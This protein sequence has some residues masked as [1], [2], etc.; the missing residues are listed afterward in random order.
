MQTTKPFPALPMSRR[1]FSA[2]LVLALGGLAAGCG[3]QSDRNTLRI[4]DQGKVLELP[5]QLAGQ[6]ANPP[7]PFEFTTFTDGPNMNAAFLAGALD[8]GMMGDTPALFASAAGADVVA[9]AAG[10]TPPNTYLQIVARPGSGITSLQDLRG[11]RV[12][13][14]KSTALHGYLLL[15]LERAG[16]TQADIT[17]IDIPIVSLAKPL[18]TGD[19]DASLLGGPVL[20]NYLEH[21]PGARLIEAPDPGYT[22]ILAS[23][24]SI[25]NAGIRAALVDFSRRSARAGLWITANPD[26]WGKHYYEGVLHQDPATAKALIER[27]G[28]HRLFFAQVQN[29][30]REHLQ[31]QATALAKAG[32]LPE[33]DATVAR[34]FDPA[35]NQ[36]FNKVIEEAAA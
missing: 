35:I 21:N 20:T 5:L 8:V 26:I 13:F 24:R 9:I 30:A 36:E 33:A 31:R 6:A 19:A 4:G 11:K 28:K 17:P 7:R 23:R 3:R 16:L 2:S 1:A 22:L 34:L 12:A 32:L 18:E 10:R 25:E 29:D 15:S 27:Q 14:T